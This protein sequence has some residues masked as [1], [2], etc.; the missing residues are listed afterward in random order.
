M[1]RY[2]KKIVAAVLTI[3]F[4]FTC[5]AC[6][7]DFDDEK[8]EKN[9]DK[10]TQ[11]QELIPVSDLPAYSDSF[12][13]VMEHVN[14]DAAR[15]DEFVGYLIAAYDTYDAEHFC[16]FAYEQ[17]ELEFFSSMIDAVSSEATKLENMKTADGF[18]AA[19]ALRN[20]NVQLSSANLSYAGCNTDYAEA[21]L[22]ADAADYER[23]KESYAFSINLY[24]ELFYGE[25]LLNN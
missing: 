12:L 18:R 1:N 20:F 5:S 4:C 25:E 2:F 3:V 23:L 17:F 14:V 13:L 15:V 6:A 9:G 11:E 7:A 24:C 22:D 10:I 8:R 21:Q 16:Q 19:L